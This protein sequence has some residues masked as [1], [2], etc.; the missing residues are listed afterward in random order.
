MERWSR[1][2]EGRRPAASRSNI[3]IAAGIIKK[4][5]AWD[6]PN[7]VLVVQVESLPSQ[8]FPLMEDS[9]KGG[10]TNTQYGVLEQQRSNKH[11]S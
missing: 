4:E 6:L 1:M 3:P 10:G 5:T 9:V 11:D 2:I 7:E 8:S